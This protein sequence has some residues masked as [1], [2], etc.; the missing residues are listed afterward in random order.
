MLHVRARH[1]HPPQRVHFERRYHFAAPEGGGAHVVFGLLGSRLVD[2]VH[3]TAGGG[4]CGRG[5]RK[6]IRSRRRSPLRVVAV[7]CVR[8]WVVLS[9]TIID[10]I[11]AFVV[12]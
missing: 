9:Q 11:S 2:R 5:M 1:R 10:R 8:V 6:R 7:G 4:A 12:R 3:C